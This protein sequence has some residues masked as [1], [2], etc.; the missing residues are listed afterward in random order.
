MVLRLHSELTLSF[1]IIAHLILFSY[2]FSLI[3]LTSAV[4]D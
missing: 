1:G 4:G 2:L 3:R